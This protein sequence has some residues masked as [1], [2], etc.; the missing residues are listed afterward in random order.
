M[1]FKGLVYS[2]LLSGGRL[3]AVQYAVLTF[4]SISRSVESVAVEIGLEK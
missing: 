4:L 3:V 2:V 1:K